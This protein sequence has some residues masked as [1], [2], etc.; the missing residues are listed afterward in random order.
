MIVI[1]DNNMGNV[2]SVQK[3]FQRLG[4]KDVIISKKPEDRIGMKK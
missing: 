4:Q 1:I 3:A 2:R